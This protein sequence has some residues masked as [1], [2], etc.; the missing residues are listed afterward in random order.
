MDHHMN[1]ID[2]SSAHPGSTTL[3]SNVKVAAGYVLQERLGSGS[4]ATVYKGIRLADYQ[5]A[6]SDASH[7]TPPPANSI[8]AIKAIS[9]SSKK[10]TKKVL[11]NLD[12]EIAILRTYRHPNIVCLHEV[13]KTDRHFYLVLEYCGGGDLQRLIRTR[14]KGRLS[15]RLCRRLVRD[16]AA[17][18]G[19]LWGKELVHRDIKPQNLLL[20]GPLPAEDEVDNP[21]REDANQALRGMTGERFMLKIADFG[22]AR[23][24]SGVDL[25]ETMCGSPLYMAPEILSG[26]KYDA[27]ADLWSVGAVLFEMIAGKT[28]FHGENHLDLLRNIKTKAVRLP[29]NVRISR[30]FVKLLKLLLDRKPRSRAGFR[31]FFEASE[32]CVALG[33]NGTPAVPPSSLVGPNATTNPLDPLQVPSSGQQI[34]DREVCAQ[35]NLCAIS[36]N[37][38]AG[39]SFHQ[40]YG[41]ASLAT[42]ATLGTVNHQQLHQVRPQPTQL[43][44]GAQ[45][46][47]YVSNMATSQTNAVNAVVQIRPD[48]MNHAEVVTPPFNPVSAPQPPPALPPG[49]QGVGRQHG[50]PS[51]FTPLQGSPVL[52]RTRT[53]P[54]APQYSL[55]GTSVGLSAHPFPGTLPPPPMQFRNQRDGGFPMTQQ[56]QMIGHPTPVNNQNTLVP[57]RRTSIPKTSSH[58]PSDS[59]FVLVEHSGCRSRPGSGH[60]SPAGSIGGI[61]RSP[62]TSPHNSSGRV[63]I[64]NARH[65]MGILGT[66]PNTGRAL[67][68]KMMIGSPSPSALTPPSASGGG[69]FNLSPRAA[70]RSGGCLAH[71]DA[72]ARMLATAEDI[73]RRSITVAH[74]GDVRAYLAM[75]L[76][77]AQREE[78]Q[79]SSMS[80]GTGTPMEGVDE[81]GNSE[82]PNPKR[83]SSRKAAAE[84][85][86]EVELPFTMTSS[87]DGM[88][89]PLNNDIQNPAPMAGKSS[90]NESPKEEITTSMIQVRFREAL[91][92]YFKTLTMMK[93]SICAAQKVMKEVEE[94]L[95]AG[96]P[97]SNNKNPYTPLKERCSASVVWLRGQFSAVLER[98]DAASEQISKLQKTNTSREGG[99]EVSLCVEELIYNHS[100]KCGREGAVKQILGHYDVA[101]SCYRSAGLLAETLL[102]ESKV[103]DDDRVVLEGYIHSFADQILELD[104]L[105]LLETRKSRA[106]VVPGHEGNTSSGTR[107]PSAA[108]NH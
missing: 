99:V 43:P 94:V 80:T 11:E 32:A 70:L 14:Q 57:N 5:R 59:G 52:P 9:R 27:K 22:F 33:C 24:L 2:Q 75:E 16:L 19:F 15:E 61:A 3:N 40:G 96:Q 31:A 105:I 73:G 37:E 67:V 21:P 71:I 10:L 48:H 90:V 29:S 79:L 100:L 18:L 84:E 34:V 91:T 60:N 41:N 17:G 12:M 101:R 68:G 92:C 85:D 83:P 102:M 95:P 74:L 44:H 6:I 47:N 78:S 46:A 7:Q 42:V 25:A 106:S 8:T 104:G 107:R 30:E 38:G 108:A 39:E 77:V 50:R 35:M 45:G 36:E 23:H 65:N 4:F 63:T 89:H 88:S 87:S 55:G 54:S 97:A 26:E 20:T 28:P 53:I 62:S 64:L 51:V 49:M 82:T 98:A 72:L 58:E 66:S 86:D 1:M 69:R 56:Q 103:G 81:E 93:G 13:Q 76:L